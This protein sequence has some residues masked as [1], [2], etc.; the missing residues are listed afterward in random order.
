MLRFL[1]CTILCI[2]FFSVTLHA[3]QLPANIN[4]ATI[5]VDNL[6]DQQLSQLLLKAQQS[7]LTI[8][9][10]IQQAEAKGM[11][12]D[13]ADKLKNRLMLLSTN[14]TTSGSMS[15]SSSRNGNYSR[16]YNFAL[17]SRAD[18]LA[19]AKEEAADSYRKRIFGAELFS[20]A[21]LTFEPNLNIPTPGNYV[22]GTN[23]ELIINVY[24]YSEKSDRLTVT[25]EGYINVQGVGP[26]LVSG[27][28]ID[29]AKV[30]IENKLTSIYSGIK[31]GNTHVQVSLGDIKGIRVMVIGAIMRPGSYTLPSLATVA[32]ALYVSGG[33]D[34]NGSFRDIQVVRG[35][36][37]IDTF[38]LYDFLQRGSLEKNILLR[39]QDI[40]KVNPYRIRVEL[41]GE[42]KRPAIFE[43]KE[44][45]TLGNLIDYAG[46]YTSSAYKGYVRAIRINDRE[47]EILTIPGDSIAAYQLRSG[48]VFDVDSVLNRF[49]NRVVIG[50][51]VF[52]PGAFSLEPGMTVKGLIAKADGV[53]EDAFT[54]RA[55]IKRLKPDYTPEVVGFNLMDALSGKA[56]IPLYREDSVF[57]YSKNKIHE[58]YYILVRGEVNQPDTI[59]Y[60]DS[61]KLG[62][63]I[64]LSG[65]L[66][67][68]ASLSQIELGRRPNQQ[69][70][71]SKDTTLAIVRQFTIDGDLAGNREAA[72]FT[73]LPF[74][75]IMVRHAPGYHEQIVVQ[76]DGQVVYPGTYVLEST[77][78]RLSDLVRRAGGLKDDAS[79]A[80]ALLMR[81]PLL[82]GTGADFEKNKQDV[83]AAANR[84]D[85]STEVRKLRSNMDSSMRLVGINLD[86][87]VKYPGSRFD[88]LLHKN[89][90]LRIPKQEETVSVY[91][92]VFY[93]KLIRFDRRSRFK[94]FIHGAGGFTTKALRRGSYIVYANGEVASTRKVLFFNHFPK[95][96]PGAEIFVPA[97]KEGQKLSTQEIIGLTTGIAGILAI[98]VVLFK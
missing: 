39:D 13:Q 47:R 66:R 34:I 11:P 15:D 7:G 24:G 44:G 88:I 26:I 46:G 6:S 74:D 55:L 59:P 63:A 25:P 37:T 68:A 98:L 3:Q 27:L 78:E 64:L 85:D 32:N 43:A 73:L 20:N 93:P 65:G 4:F 89:D 86:K 50:G 9:D 28:T 52:H 16:K 17:L 8:D 72:D 70:Y 77:N 62:D 36:K 2:C 56:D 94:D 71:D 29:E 81:A 60:S 33:P 95:V 97:K 87:A 90:V 12:Q 18:S 91:G 76:V 58:H 21:N 45:E 30:R 57:I 31:S 67:D 75:E 49:S 23:D 38:D 82:E 10:V 80:G 42:V 5:N 14:S 92:E 19:A 40:V 41:Q 79:A 51:A 61:M 69:G 1:A 54:G 22:I 84:G 53:K 83:F 35:G 96:D 48:D